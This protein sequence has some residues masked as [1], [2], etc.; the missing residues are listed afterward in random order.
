MRTRLHSR[1][2]PPQR[3]RRKVSASQS[4]P[5]HRARRPRTGR[6]QRHPR[7]FAFIIPDDPSLGDFY[8]RPGDAEHLLNDDRVAFSLRRR[9]RRVYAHIDEILQRGVT[10]LIGLVSRNGGQNLYVTSEDDMKFLLAAPHPPGIDGKWIISTIEEYPAHQRPGT[11]AVRKVLGPRLQPQHDFDIAVS[12]FA[13]RT[14][15]DEATLREATLSQEKATGE[16]SRRAHLHDLRQFPFV[17]IDGAD[18]KDFDDAV[19]VLR[20]YRDSPFALFVAIADVGFFVSA[21]S[22]LDQEARHRGT[23]IYFPGTCIPMLPE[24][25]STDLCSLLPGKERLVMVAEMH[26]DADGKSLKTAFYESVIRTAARLTYDQVHEF[27]VGDAQSR[28]MPHHLAEP[29]RS[30][31]A[32][33][34]ILSERRKRA[35]FLDFDLP[36]C[37]I[38]VDPGGKP[39]LCRR[40]PRYESHRLIEEFMIAANVAVAQACRRRGLR[41]LYRVHESP[42][43]QKLTEINLLLRALGLGRTLKDLSS[44]SLGSILSATQGAKGGA[45]LH[46]ALLRLQKQ[47]HYEPLPRGHYG[48]ALDDYTHF[49]SPIRR[50]PDL[51]VHRAL[52]R[53][54]IQGPKADKDYEGEESLEALGRLTSDLERKAMEA[55]RFVNR[56]KQCWFMKEFI[57]ER[58][59]GVISGVVS[60]G[61]FVEITDFGIEGFVSVESLEGYFEFDERACCL[62][63]RPGRERLSIGDALT[64]EVSDISLRDQ[65]ISLLRVKA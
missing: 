61:L 62:R 44:K 33:Y 30:L 53:L 24:A 35:G 6:I 1:R 9:G 8:V 11:V 20:E 55:E 22:Q 56:R 46:Q 39:L 10:E 54:I 59:K 34:R 47:A 27:Y 57:G 64:V 12:R 3:A 28:S 19:L 16:P 23:S 40:A 13:I 52:K 42:D 4:E 58:F 5:S 25:L 45:A 38:K 15:F 29:L 21:G 17:T 37:Q 49:T 51:V 7:G 50:Y 32:L 48:L 14:Q 18:A 2:T 41:C 31:R 36:E 26:F 60:R 65:S 63:R 43:P